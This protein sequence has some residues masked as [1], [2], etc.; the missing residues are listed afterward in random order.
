[1]RGEL[2]INGKDAWLQWGI[3]MDNTALSALMT[4]APCKDYIENESRLENGKRILT[5]NI[6]ADSR[7]LTLQIHLTARN[8][9]EFFSR[10]L[11]FCNELAGGVL[12]I[13][14]RYQ[15]DV[16]YHTVYN[17]CSQ[18][19]QFMRGIATFSL[20]LTEPNPANREQQ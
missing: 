18:F 11:S 13:R 14:T 1:M 12:D 4:P 8:E 2:F 16:V 5:T 3:S 7:E 6:K 9:D 20:K 15:P 19:G 17:S 10:Y